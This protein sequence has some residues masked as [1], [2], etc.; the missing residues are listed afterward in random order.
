MVPTLLPVRPGLHSMMW[1]FSECVIVIV[2]PAHRQVN[3]TIPLDIC[4]LSR[5]PK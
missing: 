2:N 5:A 4:V 3:I 1:D